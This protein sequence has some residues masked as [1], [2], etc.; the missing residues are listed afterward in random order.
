MVKLS[1]AFNEVEIET[2]VENALKSLRDIKYDEERL[3]QEFKTLSPS[4][5]DTFLKRPSGFLIDEEEDK[6]YIIDDNNNKLYC[7]NIDSGID[8]IASWI[9]DYLPSIN[10]D[11]V[12]D[13][14]SRKKL[15]AESVYI[16]CSLNGAYNGIFTEDIKDIYA[17]GKY[18]FSAL[19]A[20]DDKSQT[21]RGLLTEYK[22][23]NSIIVNSIISSCL[24]KI[25]DFKVKKDPL[26]L[27]L[28]TDEERS[29]CQNIDLKRVKII[30]DADKEI[31][32][33]SKDEPRIK[34]LQ[35]INDREVK[36]QKIFAPN[37]EYAKY[38]KV[39]GITKLNSKWITT[40]YD[41]KLRDTCVKESSRIVEERGYGEDK[42]LLDEVYQKLRKT[43]IRLKVRELKLKEFD[44]YREL[45]DAYELPL[46]KK[47]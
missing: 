40:T 11:L 19:A 45:K 22:K 12:Q 18:D 41:K 21:F 17:N 42:E 2:L 29:A 16:L 44:K 20:Y 24:Y 47:V 25:S 9:S 14:N 1:D 7:P 5:I 31:T 32:L 46:K 8:N 33:L 28:M 26:I 13:G 35:I 4:E 30:I 6:L 34:R 10:L 37:G 3:S 38:K 15:E 27:G 36:I 39:Y 23:L 43:S